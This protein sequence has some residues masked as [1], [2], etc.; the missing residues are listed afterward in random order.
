[1]NEIAVILVITLTGERCVVQHI[2]ERIIDQQEVE[3]KNIKEWNPTDD[4]GTKTR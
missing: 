3:D 2:N 4:L 1:M